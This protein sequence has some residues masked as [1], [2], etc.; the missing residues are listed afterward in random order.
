MNVEKSV[1]VPVRNNAR[2][3][4]I[5]P[6]P[7]MEIGDSIFI[8]GESGRLARATAY[9]YGRRFGKSF[10]ARRVEGGFRIWRVA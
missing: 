1:P 4:S 7:T 8:P 5:Y 3:A 10:T 9:Q 2:G 6:F